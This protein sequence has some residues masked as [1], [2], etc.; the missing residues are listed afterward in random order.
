MIESQTTCVPQRRP[1]RLN[2]RDVERPL[3]AMRYERLN[4]PILALSVELIRRSS[5]RRA[6]AN[7]SCHCQASAPLGP[8]RQR[9]VIDQRQLGGG[10]AICESNSH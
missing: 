4:S 1:N 5:D 10:E 6:S 8:R 9:K 7:N 2:E 3:Q